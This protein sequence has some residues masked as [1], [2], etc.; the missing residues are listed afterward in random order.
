MLKKQNKLL[1]ISIFLTTIFLLFLSMEF[2]SAGKLEVPL[3]GL[4]SDP[5]LGDYIS[6]IFN[7]A[8][9]IAGTIAVLALIIGGI[10]YMTSAG[11]PEAR[12]NAKKRITAAIFGMILLFSSY[13]IAKTINPQIIEMHLEGLPNVSGFFLIEGDVRKPCPVFVTDTTKIASGATILYDCDDPEKNLPI[14]IFSYPGKNLEGEASVSEL[15]CGDSQGVSGLSFEVRTKLPGV[16][17]YTDGGCSSSAARSPSLEDF[18]DLNKKVR[19]VE[20]INNPNNNVFYDV[21]LHEEKGYRGRCLKTV[22]H[23]EGQT[24]YV[25]S[26]IS[27]IYSSATVVQWSPDWKSAGDGVKFFS[28][29]FYKGGYYEVQ[30][31]EMAPIY[32]HDLEDLVFNYIGSGVAEEEQGVKPNFK[33][34]P[35]SIRITGDY[36][37]ILYT[38][39]GTDYCQAFNEGPV[40]LKTEWITKEGKKLYKVEIVPIK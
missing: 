36:L 5:E 32:E 39:K 3:P 26:G 13:L 9:G 17:F 16:Y 10:L 37:V 35:G 19:C 24:R 4:G 20:I 31:Q 29:E 18:G 15:N 22:I 6:A 14:L 38:N 8:M 33:E 30:D 27:P 34:S 7:L 25:K 12:G 21:V 40:N 11:N 28:D 2:C 1:N 23:S